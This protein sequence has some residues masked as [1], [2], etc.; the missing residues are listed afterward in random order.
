MAYEFL[1]PDWIAA[2]HEIREGLGDVGPAPVSLVMNL[3]VTDVP[4]QEGSLLAHL[5]T[6]AGPLALEASHH[7][8]PHISITIAWATAKA[9]LID[10]Q[11]QA[12]MSAFMAGKIRVEGDM[13]K[14]VALQNQAPDPR[15][16]AVIAALRDITA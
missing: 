16:D 3:T 4:F 13:S 7:P 15:A 14:L 2:A 12:V 8:T 9:L 1:S 10:G 5:N 6:D 11:S